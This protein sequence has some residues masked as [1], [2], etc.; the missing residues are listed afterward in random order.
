MVPMIEAVL[1]D[2]EASLPELMARNIGIKAAVVVEGE[3]SFV[4][5]CANELYTTELRGFRDTQMQGL[6]DLEALERLLSSEDERELLKAYRVRDPNPWEVRDPEDRI[7]SPG[8]TPAD[9]AS[10]LQKTVITV[11]VDPTMTSTELT[12]CPFVVAVGWGDECVRLS[13]RVDFPTRLEV[14]VPP[15]GVIE[16]RVFRD[17]SGLPNEWVV[18]V[19]VGRVTAGS[20]TVANVPEIQV[21]AE[22]LGS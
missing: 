13:D 7:V 4:G 11:D 20:S 16:L 9:V 3:L 5:V 15:D 22:W 21:P 14:W 10:T 17:G 18:A 19:D 8:R 2:R 12:L 1:K 6:T